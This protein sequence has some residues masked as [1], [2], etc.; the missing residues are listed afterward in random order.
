MQAI[1]IPVLCTVHRLL[2]SITEEL[3]LLLTAEQNHRSKEVWFLKFKL[4]PKF[5]E[6]LLSPAN[7]IPQF[8]FSLQ[9]N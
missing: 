4:V 7:Y 3:S 2:N 5:K 9:Q 6:N 1:L 8:H